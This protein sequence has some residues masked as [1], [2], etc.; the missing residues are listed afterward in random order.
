[1]SIQPKYRH[2]WRL[3]AARVNDSFCV[4]YFQVLEESKPTGLA[5][6]EDIARWLMTVPANSSGRLTLQFSFA[7]KLAHTPNPHAP[8]HDSL[9]AGKIFDRVLSTF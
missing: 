8:I 6:V 7:S 2:Y 3:N 4:L 1:M 5:D 9:V